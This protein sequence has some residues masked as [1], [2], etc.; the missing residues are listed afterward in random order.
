MQQ[1][2]FGS[3]G[4][5]PSPFHHTS[6][7]RD[8]G[9]QSPNVLRKPMEDVGNIEVVFS[10]GK[11]SFSFDRSPTLG[12]RDLGMK[13]PYTLYLK[14]L[15]MMY[16][17]VHNNPVI[18]QKRPSMDLDELLG[19]S[20]VWPPIISNPC[21]NNGDEDREVGSGEWVDKLMV[22]KQDHVLGLESPLGCWEPNNVNTADAFYQKYLSDSSKHYPEKSFNLYSAGNQ[23]DGN[24]TDDLDEHDAG[25]SNS[26]EPDLVW[27]FNQSKLGTF[28]NGISTKV[29]TPN[30]KQ[31]KSPEIRYYY[32]SLI[33]P[34]E[35]KFI[36]YQ[37][38]FYI[39]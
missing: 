3:P 7:G 34:V 18:R 32:L 14:V 19:N 24:S 21:Q 13:S 26:S 33:Y 11:S 12:A 39:Y 22:N 15:S 28:G 20:P 17:Q 37:K 38:M 10:L 9:M 8:L 29:Q 6:N 23:Y 5:I 1:K 36:A 4:N 27:Q 2:A 35:A 25:T 31:A 30:V 16:S